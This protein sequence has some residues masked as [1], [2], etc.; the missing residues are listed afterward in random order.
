MNNKLSLLLAVTLFT[1]LSLAVLGT[2]S[3]NQPPPPCLTTDLCFERAV[4][5]TKFTTAQDLA[6][7]YIN[8]GNNLDFVATGWSRDKIRIKT[9]N[10]D[11][12]FWGTWTKKMGDGTYEVDIADFNGDGL[13]D[14]IASNS[15]Q[16]RVYIRWG[17]NGWT[18][19]SVWVTGDQ[20]HYIATGDLNN[21]GLDDFATGNTKINNESITVRLRQA[22]GGFAP[23][24]DYPA[25]NFLS[26]VVFNDCDHD[27]DLDMF[28]SAFFWDPNDSESFVYLRRN[29]GN[30]F[31]MPPVTISMDSEGINSRLGE[32][33]FGD[34]DE[35]GWDDI[36]VTRVDHKLVRVLG[37]VNCSF[38]DPVV[39]DLD[40]NNPHHLEIGDLNGDGHLDLVVGYLFPQSMTI[41]L[42]QGN[43]N[44]SGSYEPVLKGGGDVHDVGVGDFNDDG[45][46][47]IIYAED[48]GGVWLLLGR[49]DDAPPWLNPW[50]ELNG[51]G[52]SPAGG[53]QAYTINETIIVSNFGS[54]GD[55]GVDVLLDSAALWSAD[56]DIE[57]SLGAKLLID[58]IANE[59]IASSVEMRSTQSGMEIW[60]MFNPTTYRIEYLL[61]DQVQLALT[62]PGNGQTPAATVN[63]DEVWCL[64]DHLSEICHIVF[65]T[66]IHGDIEDGI[67]DI[68]IW[69][70]S[71]LTMT[72]ADGN[73]VTADGIRLVEIP[74]GEGGSA[75]NGFSRLEVR[76]AALDSLTFSEVMMVSAEP[77]I[78]DMFLPATLR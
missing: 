72:A 44:M 7:G 66:G 64:V 45:L 28:Y 49:E 53:A 75:E 23:G 69:V 46:L 34:L 3:A 17:H 6:V 74:D 12:T 16:D 65:G 24:T 2:V 52:Y 36:V 9:G 38:H 48:F 42:G 20:P 61:G 68:G 37:G 56:I 73:L 55:D 58:T 33:A 13:T 41:H 26:D 31:F 78:F 4:K 27:G 62:L 14:I 5:V 19:H 8:L 59:T 15:E 51:V 22:G 60:P 77:P 40:N 71:P 25:A 54:N 76:G 1:L 50:L 35:N 67:N 21:D 70:P 47:D 30:G 39:A 32:M 43:G 63:W 29:E 57:G 11:G 10:G 18:G